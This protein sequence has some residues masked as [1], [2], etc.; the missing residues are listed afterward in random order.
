MIDYQGRIPD[1]GHGCR[2]A[3]RDL[4]P[5]PQGSQGCRPSIGLDECTCRWIYSK[6]I[7][8]VIV[9]RNNLYTY[10]CVLPDEVWRGI[11]IFGGQPLSAQFTGR[12]D[13]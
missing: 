13:L 10:S 9:T 4:L 5:W 3:S 12:H 7:L 2:Q 6:G 1:R 8:G 11:D